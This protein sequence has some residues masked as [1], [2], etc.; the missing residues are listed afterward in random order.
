MKIT[1]V[2]AI[3]II[4]AVIGIVLLLR[5]LFGGNDQDPGQSDIQ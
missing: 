3:L 5:F 1:V 4:A 2:G